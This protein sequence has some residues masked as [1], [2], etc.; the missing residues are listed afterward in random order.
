ML[1][2]AGCGDSPSFSRSS[3][4]GSGSAAETVDELVAAVCLAD[5][6]ERTVF[7][8][9]VMCVG[10]LPDRGG[11]RSEIHVFEYPSEADMQADRKMWDGPF[12]HAICF[13]A[14]GRIAVFKPD[15][16]GIGQPDA[17]ADL[18]ERSMRPL[19]DFDCRFVPPASAGRGA[20]STV[21]VP[22]TPSVPNTAIALPP[23][24]YGYVTVETLSG[25]VRCM[26]ESEQVI[27]ETGETNW[28][29][30]GV[31]IATDG[32]VRFADGNLG[33]IQPTKMQ[34]RTYRAMGWTIVAS[35]T[36]TRFSNDRTGRGAMVSAESVQPF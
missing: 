6:Y 9:V 13:A 31:S 25:R 11:F 3:T 35:E 5:T 26:V 4:G 14:R 2:L 12:G 7:N 28:P 23:N 33:D 34:Y 36:G 19:S 1:A 27:C 24:S 22:T 15:V 18:T 17:A 20:P 29:E 8:P 16:S 30:H 10:D 21:T 32:S